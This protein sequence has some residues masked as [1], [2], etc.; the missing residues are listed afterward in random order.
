MDKELS[1]KAYFRLCYRSKKRWEF[2]LESDPL[3]HDEGFSPEGI[4]YWVCELGDPTD[5]EW[6]RGKKND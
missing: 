1:E 5:W 3:E 4:V 6:N 2:I